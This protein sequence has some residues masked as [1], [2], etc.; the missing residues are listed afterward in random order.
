MSDFN[1]SSLC[2]YLSGKI[3]GFRELTSAEKF[4]GGQSNPTYL[5]HAGNR[6]YVLRRKPS[7]PL[8]KS[9]HAIDREF[10]VMQALQHT[11]VP[12]ARP[13][14]Y[15]ADET[16]IGTAFYVM[17][18]IQGR[19]MWDPA[20]PDIKPLQRGDIYREML[21]VLT[22]LHKV[23]PDACG[24]ADFGKPG[25]YYQRQ[26][27]RWS[28]QYYASAGEPHPGMEALIVWLSANMPEDD[29]K[30]SLVHGDFRLDNM[31]FDIERPRVLA[32][33]D[34]ELSTLGHPYA[35]L[36]YQ[37]MQLR[38]PHNQIMPGLGGLDRGAL[39]IPTEQEYVEQYC[40]MMGI[41]GIPNW[42]FYLVFSFFRLIAILLGVKQRAQQGSASSD[43][44]MEMASLIEPLTELALQICNE[45]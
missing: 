41:A 3:D 27:S 29:G 19:V 5:L 31:M 23:D 42:N 26:I 40:Q 13:L 28:K 38:M 17:E 14:H 35:D 2:L 34:W 45:D 30:T 8:L 4:N 21:R 9:A 18:Y 36:A 37:C 16:V 10:R 1:L 15:C 20:L 6:R 11:D 12:V 33:V 7:G 39:M 43:K 44:A 32:L 25:N 22:A 24:L